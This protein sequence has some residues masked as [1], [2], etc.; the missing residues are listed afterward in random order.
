M[1]RTNAFVITK[2]NIGNLILRNDKCTDIIVFIFICINNEG[3]PL[4]LPINVHI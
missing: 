4:A 2:E 1:I 3:Q